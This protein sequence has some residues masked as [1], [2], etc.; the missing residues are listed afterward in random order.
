MELLT[1]NKFIVITSINEPTIAVKSFSQLKDYQT[2]VV[3]DSK[4]PEDWN[5]PGVKYLSFREQKNIFLN[6]SKLLPINHYSRKMIGYLHAIESGA[7]IIIDT[8]D[9]N[10]PKKDWGFPVY[11]GEF[12]SVLPNLGFVNIYSIIY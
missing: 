4:T 3:G 2:L 12:Y 1:I 7:E 5:F 6:L 9:D 8:D 10:I 11:S